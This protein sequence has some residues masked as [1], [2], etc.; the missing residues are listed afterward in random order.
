MVLILVLLV[1]LPFLNAQE[2]QKKEVIA[3]PVGQ[4]KIMAWP[5]PAHMR[6]ALQEYVDKKIK[7]YRTFLRENVKGFED[8]PENVLFDFTSGLFITPE[9]LAQLQEQQKKEVIKNEKKE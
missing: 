3:P 2:E 7:E 1:I 9:G 8:M 6:D 5:L 4:D